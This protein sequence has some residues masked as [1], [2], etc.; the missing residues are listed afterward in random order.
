MVQQN[1]QPQ[2]PSGSTTQGGVEMDWN[3]RELLQR[4]DGDE[5][6]LDEL[7]Q[8]YLEEGQANLQMAKTALSEGN[9]NV[10]TR[11]AHTLKGMLRNLSMNR[12][13]EAASA[14]ENAARQGN[15]QEARELLAQLERL[16]VELQPKVEA[17]LAGVKT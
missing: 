6:F 17:H 9:L 14:L 16:V 2:E 15:S 11:A 5:A 4:L 7:L 12:A 13:G 10:L 3:M 1:R 8:I